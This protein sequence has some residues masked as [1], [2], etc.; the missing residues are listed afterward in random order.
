VEV[1][2]FTKIAVLSDIHANLEALE[3][4]LAGLPSWDELYCLG[5]LVGYGPEPNAVVEKLRELRP[6]VILAGN[7]DHAVVTG[8]S[9]GFV[10][11]AAKAIEWTRKELNRENL[12]YLAALKPFAVRTVEEETL[13]LF[14]GSPRNPLNEYVFPG[15]PPGVL[16]SLLKLSGASLLLLGHT[17]VPMFFRS[18]SSTLLNPG[19]V[20]QPRDGDSRASYLVLE[21]EPGK[22]V[23]KI[24][25][26]QYDVA[27]TSSAIMKQGLPK[28]LGERLSL[29]I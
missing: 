10:D 14:H 24:R 15:T 7:H 9:S 22:V 23:H 6:T 16:K 25:R 26:V 28:F 17:H 18:G 19:S 20:G 27:R 13:A 2:L 5:D 3:R 8:D 21:L 11:Y 4:V 29:G 12:D 1:C